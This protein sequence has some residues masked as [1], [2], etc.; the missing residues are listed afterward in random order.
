MDGGPAESLRRINQLS[1]AILSGK[2]YPLNALFVLESNPLYTLADSK[3]IKEAFDK[4]PFVVSLSSFMD[5]TAQYADLLLPNHIYLERLEDAPTPMGFPKPVV[6]LSKP[7]FKPQLNT[8]H[9]GDTLILLAKELGGGVAEAF[10]WDNFEA[11]FEQAMGDKLPALQK[12]GFWVSPTNLPD[13][14]APFK[15]P[16]GKFQF[17]AAASAGFCRSRLKVT[18]P[19]R[20][21]L[22][23]MKPCDWPA[24]ISQIRR[25]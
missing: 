1:S 15:T 7:V 12:K 17:A 11:S 3:T 9:A 16:S 22:S 20:C 14:T 5:E 19:F 25:F 8:K 10:P 18:Q 2:G 24:D 21:C 23:P 6:S 13:W 4:I